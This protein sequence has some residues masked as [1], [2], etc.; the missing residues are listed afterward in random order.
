MEPS[1]LSVAARALRAY[2]APGLDLE[3]AQVSIGHPSAAAREQEANSSNAKDL[4]NLFFY[5]VERD[6]YPADGRSD[7]PFYVRA[8]V[9][10]T[11]FSV[12]DPPPNGAGAGEKDLRL[13]G[14]AM[15]L[16][17]AQPSVPVRDADDNVVA[18]VQVVQTPFTLDD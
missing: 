9:L 14:G 8:H 6:G 12:A 10:L 16:L 5:R 13:V 15:H 2:L 1:A 18:R 4:L 11:A 7:D 17:H 3:L